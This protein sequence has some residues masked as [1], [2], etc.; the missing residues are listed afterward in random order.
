MHTHTHA[1]THLQPV[2]Q[3]G[4]ASST[5]ALAGLPPLPALRRLELAKGCSGADMLEPGALTEGLLHPSKGERPYP[6]LTALGLEGQGHQFEGLARVIPALPALR[7]L[8]LSNVMWCK[9]DV[10]G[11]I[12]PRGEGTDYAHM[13]RMCT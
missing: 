5:Q 10:R 8:H 7:H 12:K 11:C 3:G 9:F 2:F 13:K 4:K 6:A 1:R